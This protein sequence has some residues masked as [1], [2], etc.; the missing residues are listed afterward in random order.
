MSAL[1]SRH[2]PVAFSFT[3]AAFAACRGVSEL[4]TVPRS[5]CAAAVIASPTN[6]VLSVPAAVLGEPHN[7]SL[8]SGQAPSD[9]SLPPHL[10]D[11][12][13]N[14]EQTELHVVI[15]RVVSLNIAH[16]VGKARIDGRL[17]AAF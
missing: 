10:H 5:T 11:F 13:G 7:P 1:R 4:L 9:S 12:F 8:A 16:A 6:A 17:F 3:G 2:D 14:A 15:V